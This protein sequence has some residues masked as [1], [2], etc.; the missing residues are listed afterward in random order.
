MSSKKTTSRSL[1]S[2]SPDQQQRV[3]LED[4]K[5]AASHEAFYMKRCLDSDKLMDALKHASNMVGQLRTGLLSPKNYYDLYMHIFDHLK[6][7]ESYLDHLK[8]LEGK[9]NTEKNRGERMSKLYELVQYAGNILPRLYL[10]V[11]VGAAYINS[12]EAPA[13]DILQD[14]V[15]MTK[16]VQH[17]LRGLFLRNYLA[18]MTRNKLPDVDNQYSQAGGGTTEDSID[19]ILA[20][21][22]EMNK[23]WVRMQPPERGGVKLRERREQE[24]KDL[25]LLVGKTLATIG[26][27]DGL[28]E[29]TYKT[30]VFP[31]IMDQIIS[32]NDL[33]AQEYLMECV[34]QIFPDEF[35][36]PTVSQLLDACT[37]LVPGVNIK[38]IIV[39]LIDRLSQFASR[40]EGGI[41]IEMDVFAVFYENVQA[42]LQAKP[43]MD[44]LEKLEMKVALMALSLEWYPKNLENISRLLGFVTHLLTEEYPAPTR[45]TD[46]KEVTQI[47]KLLSLPLERFDPLVALSFE[48]YSTLQ[49]FLDF[50]QRSR[51]AMDLLETAIARGTK[52]GDLAQLESLLLFVQPIIG[53]PAA[54]EPEG[55]LLEESVLRHQQQRLSCVVHLC[56]HQ[57]PE[58]LL[59]LYVTIARNGETALNQD[60]LKNTSTIGVRIEAIFVPVIFRVLAMAQAMTVSGAPTDGSG[61]SEAMAKRGKGLFQFVYKSVSRV[62]TVN[63]RLG[64]KLFL[65]AGSSAGNCGFGRI[66]ADFLAQ[67]LVLYEEKLA[68]DVEVMEALTL[69]SGTLEHLSAAIESEK[70]MPLA[71][72]TAKFSHRHL[73]K[74][75]DQCRSILRSTHLFDG[76]KN[77]SA[78]DRLCLECLKTCLR[79]ADDCMEPGMN[80]RLFVEILAECVYYYVKKSPAVSAEFISSLVALI[81][82][83]VGDDTQS[84]DRAVLDFYQATLSHAKAHT[85]GLDF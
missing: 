67:A 15:E 25:R 70:Y 54:D 4:S 64:L 41:T 28:T 68:E 50:S 61:P 24:R 84:L 73:L 71:R 62:A 6:H 10:L 45:V 32:C 78:N 19:F 27:L 59:R 14:L 83:N 3:L 33:I 9:L 18:E 30:I 44:I 42:L 8:H 80:L 36:L 81:N 72:K 55:D 40:Q 79:I 82:T 35:H 75:P 7:L 47:M 60:H 66:A 46:R 26:R 85:E 43:Q 49:N 53:G 31:R 21:F 16:G 63:P 69:V 74:K 76:A 51:I 23:L 34:V 1:S 29:T 17:P 77:P 20:N 58:E 12:K 56:A 57:D 5:K 65:Q 13:K 48:H 38:R 2:L 52:I 37:K 22:T 11:A 39:C